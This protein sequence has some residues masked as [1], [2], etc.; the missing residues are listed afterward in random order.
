MPW[1]KRLSLEIGSGSSVAEAQE[2]ARRAARQRRDIYLRIRGNAVTLFSL[3]LSLRSCIVLGKKDAKMIP[4]IRSID[5]F[6]LARSGWLAREN[7]IH[8]S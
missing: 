7:S 6:I 1:W 5:L 3:F 4:S 8:D 2:E